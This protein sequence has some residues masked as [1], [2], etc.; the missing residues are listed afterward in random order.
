METERRCDLLFE[1]CQ[2]LQRERKGARGREWPWFCGLAGG[3]SDFDQTTLGRKGQEKRPH[4]EVF[5][6]EERG[7]FR[8]LAGCWPPWA[9][10]IGLSTK[11]VRLRGLRM[12]PQLFHEPRAG[13]ARLRR[14]RS[15]TA[16]RGSARGS[17]MSNGDLKEEFFMAAC[18]PK[19]LYQCHR[20]DSLRCLAGWAS[21]C[22]LKLDWVN[23]RTRSEKMAVGGKLDGIH[24]RVAVVAAVVGN[25]HGF[26]PV[27]AISM[28][29]ENLR[30]RKGERGEELR[31][32]R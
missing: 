3:T 11:C 28:A 17:W 24:G 6:Q 8:R 18:H 4:E 9:T 13:H 23:R 31:L 16:V 1:F 26:H 14:A 12:L 27:Q 7:H 15:P 2:S 5:D 29:E 19:L 32:E 10:L 21:W 22:G 25:H 30:G 20:H